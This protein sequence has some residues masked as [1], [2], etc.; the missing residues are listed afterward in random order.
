VVGHTVATISSGNRNRDINA[1]SRGELESEEGTVARCEMDSHAD[2]CVAGPN[3][4]VLEFTGEQC[5]VTPYTSDYQPITNVSVVNAV[6]AF[7]DESNGE[8]VILNFNQVLW[9]GK[10]MKMS[11]INPNQLR[12]FGITVSDDPTDTTRPFGIS[13]GEG[14]FVPFQMEGTTVYFETRV[15]TGWELENCKSIQ[16]TDST[17]WNPSNVTIAGVSSD[18][19]LPM[20]EIATRRS[21]FALRA[22]NTDTSEESCN[23]LAP[24]NELTLL[25]RM[26]GK[27]NVATAHR[28]VNVSFVGSKERHSQVNAETVARKFRCGLETAQRTLKTTTQRGVRQSIHPLHRRYRVDHLNLHQRRLNDTFYMDTLFSKIKSLNGHTCAQ[29]ITNGTFTRIYPME[30]KS[31]HNIAQ[32][33]NE[34]VD[35]VGI[36]GTLICNLASEQTGKNTEV[37]KAVRRFH[38]HLLPAEKGRGTTQNHRAETEIREV[39][40]KWKTRMRENQVPTRL[41]DYGLVY[42]AEVQSL[43]ARG[44]EQ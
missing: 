41:W 9:Y 3:F 26:I 35:D 42:I 4:S 13:T 16:V 22:T 34:F 36:P 18:P 33:L 28:D 10:R 8:T 23:D 31:S 24:Y 14:L 7:T 17:V 5:D 40:T 43:L 30:P 2:T 39:K 32:A 19:D 11:L 27:V 12:H 29:L 44:A 1:V 37:L 15:P 25:S 21:L 38:I 20:M 6:T